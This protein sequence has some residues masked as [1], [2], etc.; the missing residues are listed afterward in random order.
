MTAFIVGNLTTISNSE[1]LHII[2]KEISVD[3]CNES[4]DIK[5]ENN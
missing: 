2:L 3:F 1:K 4:P 5:T